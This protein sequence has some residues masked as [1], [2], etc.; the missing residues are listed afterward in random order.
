MVRQLCSKEA[1]RSHLPG[2]TAGLFLARVALEAARRPL[3]I[4][5]I[6]AAT[7][8]GGAGG[9]WAARRLHPR[10][11]ALILLAYVLWPQQ[12][13]AVAASVALLAVLVWLLHAA[14]AS[15]RW[16]WAA[17]GALFAAALLLYAATAAPGLLP[18]DAGEF[19]FVA[20]LLGI[21]HPPG[22]PLYTIAGYLF[23]HLLPWTSAAY[24][25]NLMSALLA[26]FTLLL[27]ARATRVWARTLGA[28]PALQ[29]AAGLAA[30][31]TLG[32]ATTFW[33]QATIANIRTPTAFFTALALYALAHFAASDGER[34]SDRA[35]TL[36]A[37]ALGLGLTHH[38]SLAF[39]AFFL[40]A[41]V[42]L[43]DP[44]L[45]TQ[46][47]RWMRPALGLTAG[48]LPLAYLPLRGL[49]DPIQNPGGLAT[50]DGFL[51][52]VLAR[53][54]AGD[55]FAFANPT[56]LPHRLALLPTLFPFQFNVPLLAAALLGLLALL[57]RERRLF[58]ALAGSIALHT[59]VAITYRAPQTVEY[60]MPAYLPLAVAV[61]LLP[62]LL[63]GRL[64][65]ALAALLLWTGVLNG[66]THAPSFF[67]L[68]SDTTA[69]QSVEPLLQA[70]PENARILANWRWFT[71]LRY[72]QVIEGQRPDVELVEVYPVA[73]EAYHDTWLRHVEETPSDQTVLLTQF[74]EFPGV[75][76]EPWEQGFLL[77]PRPVTEPAA[78]LEPV[79]AQF[80][81]QVELMGFSVL[82]ERLAPGDVIELVLAWRPVGPLDPPPS[83]TVHL[84]D[85]E[86]HSLAQVDRSLETDVAPGELRFVRLAL[87]LYPFLSPGAYHLTVGAY[88]ITAAGFETLPLADG[89][90]SLAL[91]GL[92]VPPAD[93]RP[94]TLHPRRVPFAD[95]PTLVGIDFDRSAADT[96]RVTLHWRGPNA[97]QRTVRVRARGGAE[98]V[99][100]LM[101]LPDG[102]YQTVAVD[103]PGNPR[104]LLAV[105]LINGEGEVLR[106]AGPWGWPLGELWIFAPPADA[107]FVPLGREFALVDVDARPSANGEAF[108]VDATL[109]GMHALTADYSTSVRLVAEDGR[110]LASHDGQPALG[111]VPTLKWIAG[112]RVTDRHVLPL[113][114]DFSGGG[115]S[116]TL[117]AYERFRLAP[118]VP[119]SGWFYTVPLGTWTLP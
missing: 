42:L 7:V 17:D 43:I 92:D 23:T 37:L 19:Q 46:P 34:E 91:T 20:P 3:P 65:P 112:S 107:R 9:L 50:L 106:A 95:G 98:A 8:L 73:G 76:T 1:I 32:T 36:F 115:V 117:V 60:L 94:F 100:S 88:T 41:Y 80:G 67:E 47:R 52:H 48:L 16:A 22:Y 40:V 49:A 15:K 58:V 2:A 55:M 26:A 54:F 66:A 79:G 24:S 61:G 83:F 31:L 18:A 113:P 103:L 57:W 111:A 6:L 75:T 64:A 84:T 14:H 109:V 108:I 63:K 97:A 68:A 10:W 27:L 45:I 93:S 69:R 74:Y 62:A 21:A 118:L 104:G 85:A 99:V 53:G 90:P 96:L 25:L 86:G 78:P 72:L 102:A 35:L 44:H 38:P 89:A 33:A 39:P 4:P 13:P 119:M 30:A 11:P 77:R 82:N 59:F 12:S 116:A 87:P 101:P 81:G 105:A 71:P 5:V 29:I 110:W 114:A 70:A 28:S 56:D 51:N